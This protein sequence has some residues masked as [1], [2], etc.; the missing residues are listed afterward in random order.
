MEL[1]SRNRKQQQHKKK[2]AIVEVHQVNEKLF[3]I[4]E[5]VFSL[6]ANRFLSQQD[7][8]AAASTCKIWARVFRAGTVPPQAFTTV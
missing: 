4:P 1:R 5:E 3:R 2:Q 8:A 6:L 7:V